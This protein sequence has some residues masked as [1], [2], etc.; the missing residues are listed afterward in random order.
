MATNP[1]FRAEHV[2]SLLRPPELK[3]AFS[4]F[5]KGQLDREKYEAVLT[6]AIARAVKM[7]E[8]VG[9]K[10][11]TDGEFGRGSWFGFFFERMG[12]FRLE[13]SAFKFK[14]ADGR[15]FEWPTC[16]ACERIK[17]HGGIATGEYE[18]LRRLTTQTPKVT[19]PSPSA[20]HFFRLSKAVDPAVYPDIEEYWKDLIEVYRAEIADL[21]AIGCRYIQLDEVPLAMLCD[22]L[23]QEQVTH[24]HLVDGP[25][26]RRQPLRRGSPQ[27]RRRSQPNALDGADRDHLDRH[28]QR[29]RR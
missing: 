1:P 2:G 29:Y 22:P 3:E 9:L 11:I 4:K 20:F 8:G 15:Q 16:Y 10:S 25:R 12:G 6:E 23:I 21:A 5:N 7:Q 17:R 24:R 27:A 26:R 28:P 18:R 13:P 19:L 14:D